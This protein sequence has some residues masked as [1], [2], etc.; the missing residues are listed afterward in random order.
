V[1]KL[2]AEKRYGA[3]YQKGKLKRG[4]QSGDRHWK[5]KDKSLMESDL[6]TDKNLAARSQKLLAIPDQRIEDAGR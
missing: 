3:F 1:Y 2:L 4:A 6:S 5:R